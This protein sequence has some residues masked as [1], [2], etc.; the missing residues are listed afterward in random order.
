MEQTNES[1]LY[2][3]EEWEHEQEEMIREQA[4]WLGEYEKGELNSEYADYIMEH[5]AGDR[6]ICNGHTLVDAMED[7]YLLSEFLESF[8]TQQMEGMKKC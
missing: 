8:A 6:M 4:Y 2:D 1:G 5:C 7:S 3:Q